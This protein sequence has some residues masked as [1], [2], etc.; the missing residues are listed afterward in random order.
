M[1]DALHAAYGAEPFVQVLPRGSWPRTGAV[2][3]SNSVHIGAAFDARTG[4]VTVVSALDNLIKG[5]AGQAVQNANL[6]LGFPETTG[7]PQIGVAP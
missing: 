3:G 7:L 6:A 2:L 1:E 5:A 4:R